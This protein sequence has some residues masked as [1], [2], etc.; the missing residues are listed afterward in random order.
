MAN[1]KLPQT[2]AAPVNK[3]VVGE[4]L[5]DHGTEAV[6]GLGINMTKQDMELLRERTIFRR[7]C[8]FWEKG[9]TKGLKVLFPLLLICAISGFL[10]A[11]PLCKVAKGISSYL[12]LSSGAICA[13]TLCLICCAL[14]NLVDIGR[15]YIF[16][17]KDYVAKVVSEKRV[18]SKEER[19]NRAELIA[20]IKK[21]LQEHGGMS[22]SDIQEALKL[23]AIAITTIGKII[24]ESG[25]FKQQRNNKTRRWYLDDQDVEAIEVNPKEKEPFVLLKEK[26]SCVKRL[27]SR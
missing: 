24:A 18:F 13:I 3:E 1:L 11:G 15:I 8:D 25:Q 9:Y 6:Y 19:E 16:F 2:I 7:Q 26:K 5:V 23:H 17:K 22:T 21:L 4:W 12:R 27:S 14:Y 10:F 20:L